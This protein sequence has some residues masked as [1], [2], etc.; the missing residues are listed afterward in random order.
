MTTDI[1]NATCL[2]D[3]GRGW[4][5]RHEYGEGTRVSLSRSVGYLLGCIYALRRVLHASR[6]SGTYEAIGSPR[7][8]HHQDYAAFPPVTGHVVR[9]Q[10]FA[11][12]SRRESPG[13]K[14]PRCICMAATQLRHRV[15]RTTSPNGAKDTPV[16]A[17]GG[18]GTTNSKRLHRTLCAHVLLVSTR[19]RGARDRGRSGAFSRRDAGR[20]RAQIDAAGV[21]TVRLERV[22]YR[23]QANSD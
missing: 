5:Q 12:D 18:H 4:V 14:I 7:V 10:R 9:R 15:G 1:R 16:D 19:Q 2:R 6:S 23:N 13:L 8:A 11:Y 22:P 3:H 20:W 21:H 17:G